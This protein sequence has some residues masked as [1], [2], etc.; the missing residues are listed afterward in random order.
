MDTI[1]LSSWGDFEQWMSSFVRAGRQ[2]T[3]DT[4]VSK[5]LFR[6]Q[7]DSAWQLT[8]TLERYVDR[9]VSMYQYYRALYRTSPQV[10][11]FTGENWEKTLIPLREYDQWTSSDKSPLQVSGD[12]PGYAY[13]VYLRHHGFPS[14]LLDWTRSPYVAAYFAFREPRPLES[15]VAI[16]AFCEWI[17]GHKT[18]SGDQ[19]F[20]TGLHPYVRGQ[21]R[22]FQQQSQ[23]TVC[24][25]R[26]D[27]TLWY[28]CHE[29]TFA[30]KEPN[31]DV[32]QKITIP[33][34]ERML[35]LRRLEQYNI[36]AFSLF[37]SEESLMETMAL[38]EIH[39]I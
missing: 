26:R 7:P 25:R 36:N 27:D 5:L 21:R 23:Y 37:G 19:P 22:H 3:G 33:A 16:F 38:R 6:G 9:P 20:I 8:T 28:A 29:D 31:Q 24:A 32:L 35:V 15:R 18:F 10:E 11:T 39:T 4:Y 34:S 30:L 1:D 13:F 17:M 12:F 2:A 14:P